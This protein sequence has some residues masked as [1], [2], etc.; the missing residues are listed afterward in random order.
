MKNRLW[1]VGLLILCLVF[2][3]L[4]ANAQD[5]WPDLT[6]M[7]IEI[8]GVW[9]GVEQE[10]FGEVLARFNELTGA[11]A[12]YNPI[13][14]NY[15]TVL[16]TQIEGGNPP[17]VA[18]LPQPGLLEELALKGDLV[19][20]EESV[21]KM[22]DE[23]YAQVWRDLGTIEQTLY[24]VWFKA[25]NKSLMWYNTNIFAE[26]GVEEPETWEELLE[27]AETIYYYGITPFSIGGASSWTLTD[28][29]ENIYLR[30]AGPDMYDMLLE[31]EIPWTHETVIES[32]TYLKDIF[33]NPDWLA[34]GIEGSLEAN[35]PQGIIR[36]FV[37]PPE[38][39]IVYGA[40]FSASAISN[41]TTAELGVD[42]KFFDFP[43]I[44]NSP[45]SVLGAGDVAVVLKDNEA[46]KTFVKFLATPEAAEIWASKGGFTSPNQG[47][48]TSIYPSDI[49]RRSAQTLQAAEWFRFDMSD[50][51][52]SQFGSTAGTG[53]RFW[54][55]EFLRNPDVSVT[56]EGLE[57][58]AQE[59][60]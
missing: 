22:V 16:G 60:F 29:F 6:G 46:S 41:E 37:E 23:N 50:L 32:L 58:D 44:N 20:I 43:S 30:V 10:Y 33:G 31:H 11:T 14:E 26:A 17:D 3:S 34:G 49:L 12:T 1:F 24:G 28:W 15:A 25:A 45:L 35:H 48:E 36:P 4:L 39:A 9:T 42:A 56:A 7:E 19:A 57:E 52:P 18:M 13:G 5:E 21:G 47:V 51:Q 55:Q 54:F 8:T 38:A 40:D 59:A 2:S 27:V 53:M